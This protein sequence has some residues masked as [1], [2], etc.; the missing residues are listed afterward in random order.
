MGPSNNNE[1]DPWRPSAVNRPAPDSHLRARRKRRKLSSIIFLLLLI[2]FLAYEFNRMWHD[3]ELQPA[4]FA[5]ALTTGVL[6]VLGILLLVGLLLRRPSK[7][8]DDKSI[9]RL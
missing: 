8:E 9:L 2:P 3:P 4:H 1:E 6:I 5:L 7:R